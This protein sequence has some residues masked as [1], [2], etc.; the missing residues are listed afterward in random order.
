MFSGVSRSRGLSVPTLTLR[1]LRKMYSTTRSFTPFALLAFSFVTVSGLFFSIEHV[2]AS[3][4][5]CTAP[6][7]QVQGPA[8]IPGPANAYNI[9]YVS[10]GEPFVS[11]T[12]K[13]ITFVL[14]VQTMNP[15]PA[16]SRWLVSFLVPGSKNTSELDT[17]VEVGYDTS[18]PRAATPAFTIGY[19]R[20][21][22]TTMTSS[23][24]T[25][26]TGPVTGT[27]GADG[28]I[29]INLNITNT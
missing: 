15:G 2:Q 3:G 17:T 6:Y 18:G 19:S 16:S 13:Q 8:A 20:T 14:K 11:C 12:T 4:P 22:P 21:D 1:S 28:T 25:Y 29:T 10:V 23:G 9:D 24:A 5:Q 27:V 26:F 7:V